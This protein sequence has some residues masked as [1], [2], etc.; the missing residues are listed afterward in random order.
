MTEPIKDQDKSSSSFAIKTGGKNYIK[1]EEILEV[2][3]P[4]LVYADLYTPELDLE[5]PSTEENLTSIEKKEKLFALL[6]E[7]SEENAQGVV[8]FG[9]KI[10]ELKPKSVSEV[11][12]IASSYDFRLSNTLALNVS[13]LFCEI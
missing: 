11:V 2:I 1:I 3:D 13:K 6:E 8:K 12:V 10:L 7:L 9:S 4:S 5:G